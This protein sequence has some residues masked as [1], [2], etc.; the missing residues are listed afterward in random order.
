MK[1]C[2]YK[3]DVSIEIIGCSKLGYS[4]NC[5]RIQSGILNGDMV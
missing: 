4:E 1:K 2:P 5:G 3:G